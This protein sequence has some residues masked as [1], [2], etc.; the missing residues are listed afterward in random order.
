[1]LGTRDANFETVIA[2]TG[3]LSFSATRLSLIETCFLLKLPKKIIEIAIAFLCFSIDQ[4]Y[5][6]NRFQ[7]PEPV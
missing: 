2:A 6:R 1:V 4:G 3:S 5:F 7:F